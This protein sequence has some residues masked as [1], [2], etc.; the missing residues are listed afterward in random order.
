MWKIAAGQQAATQV[1]GCLL[2]IQGHEDML[3][4]GV[5]NEDSFIYSSCSTTWC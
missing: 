1:V 3:Q 2:A 5:V 4:V